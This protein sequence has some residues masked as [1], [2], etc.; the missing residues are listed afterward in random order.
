ML[1]KERFERAVLFEVVSLVEE[2]KAQPVPIFA[3][4]VLFQ[5]RFVGHQVLFE[6]L[7]GIST[8]VGMRKCVI[9]QRK[10]RSAPSFEHLDAGRL[11]LEPLGVDKAVAWWSMRGFER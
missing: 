10:L 11:L 8:E 4:H 2:W 1:C 6:T 9:S 7:S 5:N 3:A